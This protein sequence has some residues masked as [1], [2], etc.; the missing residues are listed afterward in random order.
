MNTCLRGLEA[1]GANRHDQLC[2]MRCP[3]L[4]ASTIGCAPVPRSKPSIYRRLHWTHRLC[5]CC[6]CTTSH[7]YLVN[8]GWPRLSWRQ[9]LACIIYQGHVHGPLAYICM[10]TNIVIE[11]KRWKIEEDIL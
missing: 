11:C 6:S 2:F 3:A 1:S 7:I 8:Y 4:C 10:Q 9:S 5:P